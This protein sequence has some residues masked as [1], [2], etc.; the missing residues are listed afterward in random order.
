M[1]PFF[2]DLHAWPCISWKWCN[3]QR[4]Y[5]HRLRNIGSCVSCGS[6]IR[7]EFVALWMR[8]LACRVLRCR[9]LGV[10]KAFRLLVFSSMMG[11]GVAKLSWMATE[12][13]KA[14]AALTACPLV[15]FLCG[16]TCLHIE[17]VVAASWEVPKRCG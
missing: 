4:A 14:I 12:P 15:L 6:A 17:F 16:L 3:R 9:A 8:F 5:Q 13:W 11:L 2:R 10:L 7:A 1:A